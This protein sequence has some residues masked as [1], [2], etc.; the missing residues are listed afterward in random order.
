VVALARRSLGVGG[1]PRPDSFGHWEVTVTDVHNHE[2]P[3]HG[4]G[5]A[6]PGRFHFDIGEIPAKLGVAKQI[7]K[8]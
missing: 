8:W 7:S 2:V 6:S 3:N 5:D 1:W 4:K